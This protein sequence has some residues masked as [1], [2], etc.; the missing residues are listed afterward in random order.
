MEKESLNVAGIKVQEV[1][2]RPTMSEKASVMTAVSWMDKCW[3]LW[4][5]TR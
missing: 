4:I 5:Y 3:H 2:L 1:V